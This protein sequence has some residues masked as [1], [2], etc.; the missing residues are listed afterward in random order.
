[1]KNLKKKL[2][3]NVLIYYIVLNNTKMV[4]NINGGN[5]AKGQAR[6]LITTNK[7]SFALRIAD[8][9]LE[10]YA[11]VTKLLGNGMC[12]ILGIDGKKRLCHIRGKFRGRGKR[13]NLITLNSWILVGL[14]EWDK[15]ES[16][17]ITKGES[18]KIILPQC[19]LLEVY[20]D[21]DKENLQQDDSENNQQPNPA[22]NVP[23]SPINF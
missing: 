2:K 15:T 14:R 4:K 9:D 10:I 18:S 12:H 11:K 1:M 7:Q 22:G 6:K 5:K 13:D 21:L 19:D 23:P 20:T 8:D 16:L 3:Q 17:L